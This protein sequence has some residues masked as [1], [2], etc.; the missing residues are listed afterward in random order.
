MKEGKNK[1]LKN[2]EMKKHIKYINEKV[3]EFKKNNK[4]KRNV[5]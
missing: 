1:K 4:K 2:I 5:P 3:K